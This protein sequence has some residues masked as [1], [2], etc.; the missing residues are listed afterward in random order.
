MIVNF[1]LDEDF[2]VSMIVWIIIFW[3]FFSNFVFVV[4]FDMDYVKVKGICLYNVIIVK[5]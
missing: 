2:D 1:F 3:I 5:K 4:N